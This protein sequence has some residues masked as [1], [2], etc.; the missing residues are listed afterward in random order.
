MYNQLDTCDRN[1]RRCG[2]GPFDGGQFDE[3]DIRR[4]VAREDLKEAQEDY[5]D[6][7]PC[8][9]C[10]D[11][12]HNRWGVPW[13]VPLQVNHAVNVD[14]AKN[15]VRS[16][17]INRKRNFKISTH[18][19]NTLTISTLKNILNRWERV[20]N[21]IPDVVV[22]DYADLL[23]AEGTKEFRH[24]Q[25][26]IWKN[27]RALSTARDCLVLTATQADGK[28]YDRDL[29]KMSNYS[30]DKRKYAHVTAMFGLNQDKRGREKQI[31][32]MRINQL[33]AREGEYDSTATITVLQNLTL[34]QPFLD[35]FI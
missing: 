3:V 22:I 8:T 10:K 14:E 26:E 16:F 7:I 13:L 34:G 1:E 25:N 23:V 33:V 9:I 27:L 30:E 32:M 2:F 15:K 31:G 17:F 28:A 29:L 4:S 12:Q 5:D 19:N 11:F 18:P 35:S 21:F 20:D 24:A 6:Y